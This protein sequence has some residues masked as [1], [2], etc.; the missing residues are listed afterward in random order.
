MHSKHQIIYDVKFRVQN[1]NIIASCSIEHKLIA[2]N[3]LVHSVH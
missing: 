1:I 2:I 3:P